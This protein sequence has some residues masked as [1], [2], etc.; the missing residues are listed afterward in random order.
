MI[1]YIEIKGA[2]QHNLKNIDVNIPKNQ[3]VVITGVSGSGKSSLAFDTLYAEGQRRYVESLS[4]YARQFIG[5]MDKPLYDTIKGLSPAISIEQK[6]ASKN[7]RST[8][9]TI[10]EINDYLRVLYARIGKQRCYSCGKEVTKQ[11]LNEIVDQILKFP[12]NTKFMITAPIMTNRKGEFKDKIDE[13]RKKGFVRIKLDGVVYDVDDEINI[14]KNKKHNLSA[15]VDRLVMKDDIK[16]RLTQSIEKALETGEGIVTIDLID[17]KKEIMFSEHNVCHDCQISF[18]PLTPQ[19][20]SFNNPTGFCP[21]CNGLGFHLEPDEDKVIED[22]NK[23]LLDGAIRIIVGEEGSWSHKYF[24]TALKKMKIDGTK[25]YKDL[26]KEEKSLVLYGS[27]GKVTFRIEM[28]S[29]EFTA[30]YEGI[31]NT[32]KRRYYE[33]ES[34]DAK[35]YYEKYFAHKPCTECNGNRLNKS[36]SAVFI[37]NKSIVDVSNMTIKEAFDF[38]E[39]ANLSGNDKVIGT[40]LI[41]EVK[42]R[43]RFLVNVGLD[44]LSLSRNGTTLSGGESQRIRLASQIGSELTGVIYILDEPSIGLHQ[45]DNDKLIN[46]LKN[47]RDKDNTVIVIEHDKDTMI[48]SDYIIDLGP[49][50]GEFGGNVVFEGTPEEILKSS[51]QTGLFLSGEKSI[52]VPKKR[53]EPKKWF[54]INGASEN[55]LKN[56]SVSFPTGVLTLVTG[57]SGAGKSTLINDILFPAISNKLHKTSHETGKHTSIEGLEVFDKIINIDQSPIGKTPRSNPATYTKLFDYIRDFFSNLPESKAKGYKPGR[58][59]FNVKGGR[60]EAC[61][62]DGVKKVEMHFLAD[63]YVQCEVCKGQRFNDATLQVKYKNKNIADILDTYVSEANTLFEAHPQIKRVLKTLDE[64]GLSYIKLGQPSTTLSGGEAQRIKLSK[65][66][67][68]R[69]TGNTLYI[70]DEPSTGLHFSDIEKLLT[71]I[72]Q[73]VDKGNTVVMIEH[74]L[75]II[76]TAD[77]II[78][79]GPEGGNGGGE[80]IFSGTPEE[81]IKCEKSYTGIHLKEYL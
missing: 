46:T 3:F 58:F 50:A 19:L 48:Q 72:H 14:D 11:T 77:Y 31:L 62:G 32:L 8:V 22:E 2:K 59:S 18:P 7:P 13:I 57:V 73:L 60:C 64:V 26:T 27:E 30:K 12:V 63:V 15:V 75:D 49:G 55:N 61:E 39:N 42:N 17:E 34:E 24:K 78:D 71:I 74:N 21:T 6:S 45:R 79:I 23:P 16:S 80:V 56:I 28:S 53:R 68:K 70:L 5:Q 65:E 36:S 10:T 35:Q 69:S 51:T 41:K 38:F 40:E 54:T 52:F 43:L 20:F 66:L 25:L 4:S 44:Y 81:I 67:A 29:Y 47:L 1:K 33:T 37:A 76:K 9:G